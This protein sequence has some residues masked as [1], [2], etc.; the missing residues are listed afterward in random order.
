MC[1][2]YKILVIFFNLPILGCITDIKTVVCATICIVVFQFSFLCRPF[3]DF[4]SGGRFCLLIVQ[5][6]TTLNFSVG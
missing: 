2:S 5:L 3:N 6:W 4:F 1:A